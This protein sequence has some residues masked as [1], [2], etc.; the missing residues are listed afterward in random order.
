MKLKPKKID[1]PLKYGTIRTV[2]KFAFFPVEI[3]GSR[4]WWEYYIIHQ[5][6]TEQGSGRVAYDGMFVTR[7]CDGWVTFRE[8]LINKIKRI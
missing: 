6:W 5:K 1:E 8:E 2:R 7:Y 3:N 4:I